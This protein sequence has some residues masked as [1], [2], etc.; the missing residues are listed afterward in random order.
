MFNQIFGRA[1]LF[2]LIIF[3][4]LNLLILFAK[5]APYQRYV[6]WEWL[7]ANL[8]VLFNDS[9]TQNFIQPSGQQEI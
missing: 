4:I 6:A 1:L 7:N 8:I 2:L 5:T 9:V 3:V